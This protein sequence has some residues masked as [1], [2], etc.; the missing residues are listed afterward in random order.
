MTDS[1]H[2]TWLLEGKNAWNSRREIQDFRP[3]FSSVNFVDRFKQ[4]CKLSPNRTVPLNGY[5]LRCAHF[6]NSDLSY[7]DFGQADLRGARLTGTRYHETS[8][9]QADLT[10]AEF[11][12]GYLG[13]VNLSN[14]TLRN[15]DLT[16][17]RLDGAD[18]GWSRYWQAKLYSDLI[19]V[20]RSADHDEARS[21]VQTIESVAD[22]I[23]FCL[24]MRRRNEGR[25]LYFRGE[26]N[27]TWDLRPSVMRRSKDMAFKLRSHEGE[28][29]RSLISR[30]PEDF[31]PM[32]SALEQMVLAQHHGLKTRLLDVTRNPC[33]ALFS[34]CESRDPAC[35]MIDG[36]LHVFAVQ[37]E[38]VKPFDSDV[39]SIITNFAKLRRQYQNLLLGKTGEESHADDPDGPIA[40]D[41][42][43]A[44]SDLYHFIR[45][46]KPNF[47]KRIDPRHFV[48]VFFVE[49]KQKFERIRAQEGA[50]IISAFH[51][52]FEPSHILYHTKNLP[53]YEY[54]TMIVPHQYKNLLL[55]E[56]SL[57]NFTRETLYP[58][59]D[60]VAARITQSIH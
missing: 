37:K 10:D 24:E 36:R 27:C 50:F 38:L 55:E 44:M 56:L 20:A 1:D 33:V 8:F 25:T 15:T 23:E 54:N 40:Y 43:K 46:E 60:E 49:P 7:V 13:G 12:V 31:A 41:Y 35:N 47:E 45:Q 51:E 4:A 2:L 30:R 5:D 21:T 9:I 59:L 6:H 22:L 39:V 17:V 16:Q 32:T 52:R 14:A 34:T 57:L 18:L 29:L 58:S 19:D 11:G 3:Y 53:V 42:L 26:C 28:M 48:S